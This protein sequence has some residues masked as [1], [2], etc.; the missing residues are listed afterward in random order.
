MDSLP[1]HC[2]R[3]YLPNSLLPLQFFH[4]EKKRPKFKGSVRKARRT[5]RT[6]SKLPNIR[7]FKDSLDEEVPCVTWNGKLVVWMNERQVNEMFS[8]ASILGPLAAMFGREFQQ[9]LMTNRQATRMSTQDMEY[10]VNSGRASLSESRVSLL[11]HEPASDAGRYGGRAGQVSE[12]TRSP[13]KGGHNRPPVRTHHVYTREQED[14]RDNTRG[15]TKDYYENRRPRYGDVRERPDYDQS[16]EAQHRLRTGLRGSHASSTGYDNSESDP[17]PPE[18]KDV[19]GSTGYRQHDMYD[20]PTNAREPRYY[21]RDRQRQQRH[22]HQDD[23]D[24]RRR[25]D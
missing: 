16:R 2:R 19:R 9:F 5:S 15:N 1:T 24:Y 18:E 14:I 21:D 11:R 7:E 13:R 23:S 25:R 20:R 10:S 3:C 8:E 6:C 12:R 22:Y 4:L 17:F